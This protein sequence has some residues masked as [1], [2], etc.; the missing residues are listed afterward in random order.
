MTDFLTFFADELD[1]DPRESS[2][3]REC[4]PDEGA[5]DCDAFRPDVTSSSSVDVIR[6]RGTAKPAEAAGS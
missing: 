5:D 2:S 6:E 1:D 4:F 3:S